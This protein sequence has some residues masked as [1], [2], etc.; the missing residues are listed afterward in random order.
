MDQTEWAVLLHR[1]QRGNAT[2]QYE[3]AFHYDHGCKSEATEIVVKDQAEAYRWLRIA[4]DNGN[5]D[6]TNRLADY[7]SEG[8]SCEKNENEAIRLYNKA[9]AAG[10]ACAAINLATV[11][12]DRGE[13]E[14]AFNMYQVA[15][16]LEK[17][18][19]IVVAFCYHFGVGVKRN[20]T[21]AFEMFQRISDLSSGNHFMSDVDEAHYQL[22]MYYLHGDVVPKSI[23]TARKHFQ[24][25]NQDDD[26]DAARQMLTVIGRR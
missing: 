9:I 15:Q 17:Y 24:L 19:L 18:D 6:A 4:H 16:R 23:E 21:K 12:R 11:Y 26:H 8:I 22:G 5:I 1:A 3:V 14:T 25:A 2:A 13:L 20:Q 10:H 7:L